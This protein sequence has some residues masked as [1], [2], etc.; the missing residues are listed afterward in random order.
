M[1]ADME[2]EESEETR[3]LD[4]CCITPRSGRG[5]SKPAAGERPA[6]CHPFVFVYVTRK[7]LGSLDLMLQA[8][9]KDEITCYK[10]AT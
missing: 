2:A 9:R 4:V 7:A 10:M 3:L 6:S 5:A 8:A 1:L